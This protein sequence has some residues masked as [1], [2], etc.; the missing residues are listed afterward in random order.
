MTHLGEIYQLSFF[1]LQRIVINSVELN[2]EICDD[3]RFCKAVAGPLERIRR[4][5]GDGLFTAYQGEHNWGVA[6][7]TLVPAFGPIGIHDMCTVIP[8][9]LLHYEPI[10]SAL[11]LEQSMRCLI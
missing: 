7:R 1:G 2:E 5:V 10:V 11:T 8:S 9:L 3:K 6:H 4:G